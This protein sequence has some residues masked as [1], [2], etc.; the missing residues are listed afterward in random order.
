MSGPEGDG[1]IDAVPDKADKASLLLQPVNMAGLVLRKDFGKVLVNPQ[2]FRHCPGGTF[3]VSGDDAD[4]DIPLLQTLNCSDGLR[5]DRGPH[6]QNAP[7]TLVNAHIDE[8][9]SGTFRLMPDRQFGC[10]QPDTL[11]YQKTG[12]AHL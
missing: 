6:F 7:E 10:G 9:I 3:L 2:I 5:P 11:P 4:S 8:G 1:I 12:A